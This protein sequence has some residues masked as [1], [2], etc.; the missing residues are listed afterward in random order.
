MLW[1]SDSDRDG[2]GDVFDSA[3]GLPKTSVTKEADP[4]QMASCQSGTRR[5]ERTNKPR[6]GVASPID[7][8]TAWCA[9][10]FKN[11]RE[12]NTIHKTEFAD[13]ARPPLVLFWLKT[14]PSHLC[15]LLANPRSSTCVNPATK[16]VIEYVSPPRY[17][18]QRP[19]RRASQLVHSK[20]WGKIHQS[21]AQNVGHS[22]MHISAPVQT[23]NGTCPNLCFCEL[24]RSS[25][26][27]NVS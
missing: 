17:T 2:D 10:C 12:Q 8:R 23:L 7:L 15:V 5:T 24:L 16:Q 6:T 1:T 20:L 19:T 3:V 14:T 22:K 4:T 21:D 13:P 11:E 9:R 26:Q 18:S 27:L 25:E